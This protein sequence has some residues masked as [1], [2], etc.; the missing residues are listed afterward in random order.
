MQI[1]YARSE[2]HLTEVLEKICEK[3]SQYA[4]SKD[5]TTGKISYIRTSSRDGSPVNLSNVSLSGE[6]AEKLKRAV[7]P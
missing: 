7:S 6:I 3:M 4:E 2:T 1:P 5:P